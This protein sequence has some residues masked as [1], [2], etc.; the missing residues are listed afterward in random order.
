MLTSYDLGPLNEAGHDNQF[1]MHTKHIANITE[2]FGPGPTP[3]IIRPAYRPESY[4]AK[5]DNATNDT[6][7]WSAMFAAIVSA[8]GGEIRLPYGVTRIAANTLTVP[9]RCTIR[10]VSRD[11]S[12][13]KRVPGSNGVLLAA[14]GVDS[15]TRHFAFGMENL[16]IQGS[17]ATGPMFRSIYA[18]E[19]EF[20]NVKF[21]GNTGPAMQLVENWDSNYDFVF[22]EWCGQ[23]GTKSTDNASTIGDE[24]IQLWAGITSTGSGS[25]Y[26]SCNNVNF[27]N[28][29]V[30]T[31]KAPA[32][33]LRKGASGAGVGVHQIRFNGC[34]I[35]SGSTFASDC[36][37]SFSADTRNVLFRDIYLAVI[38]ASGSAATAGTAK[39]VEFIPNSGCMFSGGTIYLASD[40]SSKFNSIFSNYTNA[41]NRLERLWVDGSAPTGGTTPMV[42][43][44]AG[45]SN[46][47]WSQVELMPGLTGTISNYAAS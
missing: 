29:R 24:P 42:I 44:T 7:A 45:G 41:Q 2:L 19:H 3:A 40:Q 28:L 5:F 18:S 46:V 13:I 31:F 16:T 30:E 22:S 26:D 35:E 6:A 37:I 33:S 47:P 39:F 14:V 15:P 38:S 25:S 11:G 21:F 8:G 34:K 12:I 1:V 9:Q 27:N 10:G 43:K 23:G 4:G 32:L 36:M 20:R 17:D